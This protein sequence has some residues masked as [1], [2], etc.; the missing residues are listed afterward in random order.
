MTK[1][2]GLKRDG[3]RAGICPDQDPPRDIAE[4][5]TGLAI[6]LGKTLDFLKD[7]RHQFRRYIPLY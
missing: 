5:K 6:I 2:C 4:R 3:H 1:A 7:G